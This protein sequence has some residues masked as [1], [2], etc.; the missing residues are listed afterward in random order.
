MSVCAFTD[1]MIG[2]YAFAIFQ[3]VLYS[4]SSTTNKFRHSY[5][6]ATHNNVSFKTIGVTQDGNLALTRVIGCYETQ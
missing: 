3:S 4:G 5:T 1:M 2:V 6:L